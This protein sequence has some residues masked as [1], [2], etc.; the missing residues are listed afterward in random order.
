[1]SQVPARLRYTDSNGDDQTIGSFQ[2]SDP[3]E[4]NISTFTVEED[5]KNYTRVIIEGGPTL[6]DSMP[7]SLSEFQGDEPEIRVQIDSDLDGTW[8]ERARVYPE[9]EGTTND[10]GRYKNKNLWGFKKYYG[11]QDV[12]TGTVNSD[13]EAALEA[14]LP[15]GYTALYPSDITAPNVSNYSFSGARQQGF[16]EL[17]RY[18]DHF[19]FFTTSTDGNGDIIVRL[20]PKGYGGTQ[21]SLD[22]GTDAFTYNY[23]KKADSSN[24]VSKVKVIGKDSNGDKVERVIA[25]GDSNGVHGSDS[26]VD[27]YLGSPEPARKKFRRIHVDYTITS[28][29]A[30]TIG[31]NVI[32]AEAVEQGE[33]EHSLRP[34]STLN[35]SVGIVDNNRTPDNPINDIFTVVKQK[36]FF[37]QGV[38]S[39][40]FEFEKEATQE[41]VDKWTEHDFERASIYPDNQTDVGGQDAGNLEN[42]SAESDNT[43]NEDDKSPGTS[44][45]TGFESSDAGYNFGQNGATVLDNGEITAQ[46][47]SVSFSG[48]DVQ[49]FLVTLNFSFDGASTGDVDVEI[50]NDSDPST[51][52]FETFNLAQTNTSRTVTIIEQEAIDG[53]TIKADVRNNTGSSAEIAVDITVD[54]ISQHDHT[55]SG[56]TDP[57]NHSVIVTDNGHGAPTDSSTHV[58]SGQTAQKLLDLLNE[59][60]TDR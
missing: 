37:H 8:E 50:F 57:H 16:R 46:A 54:S 56:N 31:E 45:N 20:Q 5:A 3:T 36:D 52:F 39:Y 60:K 51:Y 41:Q 11:E 18:Y 2:P 7:T 32:S 28:S 40:S 30:D 25:A 22:R 47:D 53:D 27:T 4:G 48:K 59:T 24:V 6:Q 9:I 38:T 58:I 14:L 21:F 55:T 13:L 26:D 23:W 33:I 19:I 34:Q 1:M 44:G 15:D 10:R 43:T 29:E 35:E 49:I 42:D 17:Q 12:D